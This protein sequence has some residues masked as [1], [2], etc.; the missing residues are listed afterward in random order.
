MLMVVLTAAA[1]SAG[2]EPPTLPRPLFPPELRATNCSDAG[3][4]ARLLGRGEA[5]FEAAGPAMQ[6]AN[7]RF[8]ARMNAHAERL[9]ER[10]VWT[11]VDRE[12]FTRELFERPAFKSYLSDVAAIT[13]SMMKSLEDIMRDPADEARSCR[14]LVTMLG[15]IDKSV[16]VGEQGWKLLDEAYAEEARRLGVSLD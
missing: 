3:E 6:E 8:E 11:K 4:R 16:R 13:R 14:A 10:R 9:I 15:E 1:F 12:R 2:A 7:A 5:A